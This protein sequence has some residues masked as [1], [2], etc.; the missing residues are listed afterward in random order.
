[1]STPPLKLWT[2]GKTPEGEAVVIEVWICRASSGQMFSTH[3]PQDAEDHQILVGWPSGGLEQTI[4]G[5]LTEALR[6]EAVLDILLKESQEPGY[7][8]GLL[9]MDP[10][11]EESWLGEMS[12]GLRQLVAR[13]TKD[14]A[15]GAFRDV[16]QMLRSTW[17]PPP[18]E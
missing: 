18:A 1:M 15:P 13:V 7:L 4:M 17:K 9:D 10:K 6:K 16:L 3:Q 2:K 8:K 12:T 11:K 5:L 14:L